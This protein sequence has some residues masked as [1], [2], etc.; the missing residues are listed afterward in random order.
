MM[1]QN[2]S[3]CVLHSNRLKRVTLCDLDAG[4][5]FSL[6]ALA[7]SSIFLISSAFA[8][9]ASEP[10]SKSHPLTAAQ[11]TELKN[12]IHSAWQTLT[13]S[14][15]ECASLIDTKLTTKPVL[16]VPA[17]IQVPAAVQQ[18]ESKC[19]TRVAKLPRV[20]HGL[21]DVK[22]SEV[23][24]GLLYLPNPYVVPGGRF[25]EMYG[26]DSYFIIRGLVR[27]GELTLARD[28]IENFFF[29]IEHYGAVLNANRTYY[30][31]RSQPPFLTSMIIAY[32]NAQKTAGKQDREWLARAYDYAQRDYQLWTHE[33]KL[34]G[35]TGLSRYFDLGEGPVPEMGDDPTYYSDVT[36][37][38]L[39]MGSTADTYLGASPAMST[40]QVGP[41]FQLQ[42]CAVQTKGT[43]TAH[44]AEA[45]HI[46]LS[47][48]YYKGDRAMRES[49]FDP[50]FRFGPYSGS[51][52]H[53]APVCLNSLLYKEEQDLAEMATLLGHSDESATWKQRAETR[54]AEINK[55]FWN[56]QAGMFFDYDFLH[57]RQSSYYYATTF[58][59]LWAGLATQEQAQAVE[60]N[61]S[62]FEHEG[63][64]AM[65]DR[66]TGMQW[67]LP[68]GWA[69]LQL[70]PVEGLRRYGF[71][72]DADRVSQEFVSDV[73]DNFKRDQTIREKYDVITRSTQAAV[74]AGYKANVVGFGWTNG[75]TLV[76]LDSKST[77]QGQ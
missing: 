45:Q 51:T 52:H 9:Q 64:I 67:D 14:Q 50:S 34:A 73:Y 61:L 6:C 13:R 71:N 41:I 38:L 66:I 46:S 7:I 74:S 8:Q 5:R 58:Y 43:G 60:H 2:G 27:D 40:A 16:Y 26:W 36:S 37:N 42:V 65:S 57:D 21:G 75:V 63:G 17:D 56:A 10:A 39:T 53:F 76:L 68:Y 18:V 19:G 72:A 28:M 44:C 70:L 48:D 47:Q 33:P 77:V 15:S 30:F 20:I 69:P 59:P 22:T 35:N 3:A 29:E 31:T 32:Y 24:A 62:L 55:Y 23:E 4:F 11:A 25:N 49:G 12:Y 54:K 1:S